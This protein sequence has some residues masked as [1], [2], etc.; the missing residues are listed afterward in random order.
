LDSL[1]ESQ[2]SATAPAIGSLYSYE[3]AMMF[4]AACS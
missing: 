1:G 3:N 2:A 4:Y